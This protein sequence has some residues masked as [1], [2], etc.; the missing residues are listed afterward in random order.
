M[1]SRDEKKK[2][3]MRKR[4]ANPTLKLYPGDVRD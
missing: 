4:Y 2:D 3:D 1:F